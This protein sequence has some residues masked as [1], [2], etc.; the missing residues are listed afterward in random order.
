[1]IEVALLQ[2]VTQGPGPPPTG[3]CIISESLASNHTAG[4]RVAQKIV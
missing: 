4:E 2:E 1:M 3:A